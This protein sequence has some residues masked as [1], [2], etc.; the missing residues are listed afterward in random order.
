M[1]VQTEKSYIPFLHGKNNGQ[2]Y[3][4]VNVIQKIKKATYVLIVFK[5]DFKV[6]VGSHGGMRSAALQEHFM[7]RH[8]FLERCQVFPA[9]GP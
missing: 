5:K 8:S 9:I 6:D 2:S 1:S 4:N 3:S 7:H